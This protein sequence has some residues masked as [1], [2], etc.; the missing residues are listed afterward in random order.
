M[1]RRREI[2][3]LVAAVVLIVA[4]WGVMS[5]VNEPL[6][7]APVERTEDQNSGSNAPLE[8]QPSPGT[9]ADGQQMR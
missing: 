1:K 5:L 7:T 8:T 2:M 3:V 4:V 9:G 6:E